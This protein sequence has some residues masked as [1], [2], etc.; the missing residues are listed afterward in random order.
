MHAPTKPR[1]SAHPAHV[2]RISLCILAILAGAG[3]LM[4]AA[5]VAGSFRDAAMTVFGGAPGEPGFAPFVVGLLC[6]I[7]GFVGL[8]FRREDR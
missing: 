2:L 8:V 7:Y 4:L 3:F 1:P 6:L 5:H